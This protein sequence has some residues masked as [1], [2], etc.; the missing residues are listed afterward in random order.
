M[1]QALSTTRN[2]TL[3]RNDFGETFLYNVNRDIFTKISAQSVYDKEFKPTL[4]NENTLYILVGSDSGLLA[5]YILQ[6][7]KPPTGTRYLFVE[8]QDILNQLKENHLIT[9]NIDDDIITF[10]T[11]D[12][13]EQKALDL[14]LQEYSYLHNVVL[15]KSIGAQQTHISEYIELNWLLAERLESLQFQFRTSLGCKAFL[16][17]QF[18]NIADNIQP[19]QLLNQRYQDKTGIVLAGGPSLADILPWVKKNRDKL[20]IFAVSRIS[21]ILINQHIE[22]DIVV[23][24]D[25][26]PDNIDVSKEM[27]LFKES[28]FV[29]S[30][31]VDHSM[32]SQWPGIHLYLDNR[33]P[34]QTKL[35][36]KNFHSAGS[37]VSNCALAIALQS[38]CRRVLLAG[39]DLC[40]SKEGIT[41]TK[42]TDEAE[43]GPN[44]NTSLLEVDTYADEK[45][46]SN[47][48]FFIALQNLNQQ[49][50]NA[51]HEGK[52]VIN[53]AQFAAKADSISYRSPDS[54]DFEEHDSRS[55]IPPLE[56]PS[57]D[58]LKHYYQEASRE[59]EQARFQIQSIHKLADKALYINSIMYN[60]QGEIENYKHKQ[61][62]DKIE[63]TLKRK[64]RKFN[65]LVK[66]FGIEYFIRIIS[67]H[68]NEIEHWDAEKAQTVAKI[69]YQSY[70]AGCKQLT[71]LI[72]DNLK[73]LQTRQEELKDAP[74]F[75]QLFKQ[76]QEDRSYYRA[77]IW[78]HHHPNAILDD[79]ITAQ[80]ETFNKKFQQ[81]LQS[82]ETGFKQRIQQD[83]ALSLLKPRAL[84]LFNHR[85]TNELN[86]LLS[87]LEL[88]PASPKE[89]APYKALI[90][91]Y[92]HDI[93][94]DIANA[95]EAYNEVIN[96]EN[97]DLWEQALL[98]IASLSIETNN[99]E[100]TLLALRCLSDISPLYLPYYAEASK[101]S[102]NTLEAIDS[103]NQ[104]IAQFPDD[105]LSKIQLCHLYMD[106]GIYDAVDM[107]LEIILKQDPESH[108]A[109][110]L[111][112]KNK[113]LKQKNSI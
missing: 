76:W 34:W 112:Q 104:Y 4:F 78:Q 22:P 49:G 36:L 94:Q 20:I 91:A 30:F 111:Q 87:G 67:P 55:H 109:L 106:L 108:A 71:Q 82:T 26:Q 70:L 32:A 40:L 47:P 11:Q 60:P 33:F 92:I 68:D 51:N 45:R 19:A 69:Y 2:N 35:N 37:T 66:N 28:I 25:P 93:N 97:E 88:H 14:H 102:D 46:P 24:V 79:E 65:T 98:R 44:F 13:W 64:Y 54:I 52:Q 81:F 95:L 85:K 74:D 48:D 27:F 62:L 63:Q 96:L 80:L 90:S 29:H 12:D 58:D 7:P 84:V 110:H 31:H 16:L 41:H 10:S 8:P 50:K 43:L 17:L 113:T 23:S 21:R 86:N 105:T 6:Q 83:S 72:D 15:K 9:Q 77:V 89:K 18:K 61:E 39:F 42:G 107:M 3:K 73:R 56:E 59:L 103:L 75:A 1:K 101:L 57:R 5:R 38:G 99:Q 53:L 100:N